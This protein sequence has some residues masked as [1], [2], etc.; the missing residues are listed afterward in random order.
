MRCI[1][2]ADGSI[3]ILGTINAPEY[4]A[5]NMVFGWTDWQAG[6]PFP[7]YEDI[8]GPLG[9]RDSRQMQ[10]WWEA[11]QHFAFLMQKEIRPCPS[12]D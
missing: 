3:E 8:W 7:A 12:S 6:I 11:T 10:I 4:F 1:R 9:V 2:C 5:Q